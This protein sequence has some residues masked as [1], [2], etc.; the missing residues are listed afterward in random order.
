MNGCKAGSGVDV[1]RWT[2]LD[3]APLDAFGGAAASSD[4]GAPVMRADGSAGRQLEAGVRRSARAVAPGR[5]SPPGSSHDGKDGTG[6]DGAVVRIV[7]F[8]TQI[9][10]HVVPDVPGTITLWDEPGTAGGDGVGAEAGGAPA[11][12]RGA[13]AVAEPVDVWPLVWFV[14][15]ELPVVAPDEALF[16]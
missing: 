12:G 14:E 5:A 1:G 13:R 10:F 9:Q 2:L 16:V 7:Q 8:Q 4:A 11:P 6:T 15:L 3:E